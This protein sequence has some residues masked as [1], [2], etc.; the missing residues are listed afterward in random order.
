MED[1]VNARTALNLDC[2]ILHELFV[3]FLAVSI[4]KLIDQSQDEGAVVHVI[5]WTT[6]HRVYLVLL[7]LPLLLLC[8]DSNLPVQ[9][10]DTLLNVTDKNHIKSFGQVWDSHRGSVVA[11]DWVFAEILFLSL[12]CF[13]YRDVVNDVLLRAT[14][15][16]VVAQLQW[17]HAARQ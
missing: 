5:R 10:R 13:L 15:D 16:A 3:E 8:S 12:D 6:V 14:L 17:I 4:D 2:R 9:R 11:V 7:E 1:K